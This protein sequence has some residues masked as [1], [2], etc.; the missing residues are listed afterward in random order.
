MTAEEILVINNVFGVIGTDIRF[1][2]NLSRDCYIATQHNIKRAM[3]EYARIKCKEL[4]EI[5][6]EK[7]E[8]EEVDYED[9]QEWIYYH[10]VNKDSILNAVDLDKFIV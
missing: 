5:V 4:L 7:A 2:L 6:A 8:V 9:G 1:N 10:K 3:Q